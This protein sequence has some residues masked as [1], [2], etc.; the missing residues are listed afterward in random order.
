MSVYVD[1]LRDWGA[2]WRG[3]KSCH[4][5]ADTE[6]ELDEFAARVG[7]KHFWKQKHPIPHFD[8]GPTLRKRALALGAEE[9]T[10]RQMAKLVKRL[11]EEVC[12]G[13]G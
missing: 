8:I 4:V 1:P 10:F 6:Q 11:K 12:N 9:I 13:N 3:G 2:P 7:A 5:L